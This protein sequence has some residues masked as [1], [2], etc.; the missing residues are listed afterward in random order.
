MRLGGA[1]VRIFNAGDIEGP[2]SAWMDEPAGGWPAVVAG[3]LKRRERFPT[4]SIH[5][6]LPNLSVLVDACAYDSPLDSPFAIA[7]YQ[8]PPPLIDRLR[9][10]GIQPERIEHVVITHPHHDHIGGL[11][12]DGRSCF[13]RARHYLA[14]AD[15]EMPSVQAALADAGS[16][17]S[18]TLGRLRS[19]GLL[20]L[21]EGERAL[22]DHVAIVPA[23]G[24][25]PGHQLVRLRAQRES[26]YGVGDLF[27]H[28]LEAEHPELSVRWA[29]PEAIAASRRAL[30]NA[31]LREDAL[32]V[33]THI[34]GFGRLERDGDGVR[35]QTAE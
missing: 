17:E 26:L 33:A 31:A 15:W 20:E 21:V 14:R 23:L 7:G 22:G 5:I 13:P 12:V 19:E 11:T 8:P 9:A 35:W 34:P 18:R 24:E 27:H 28:P 32:L 30:I 1:Q 6:A 4:Q 29:I 16:V 10:A 25:T 3:R 2:L